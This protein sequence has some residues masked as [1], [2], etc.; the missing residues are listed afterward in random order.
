MKPPKDLL[1]LAEHILKS[2]ADDFVEDRYENAVVEMTQSK[3]AG[4]PVQQNASQHPRRMLS[5]QRKK[6]FLLC[7]GIPRPLPGGSAPAARAY[8]TYAPWFGRV[9]LPSRSPPLKTG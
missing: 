3:R 7:I 9:A 1:Q 2:K 5:E 6:R 8:P 4:T